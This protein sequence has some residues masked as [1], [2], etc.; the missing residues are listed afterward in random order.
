MFSGKLIKEGAGR[1]GSLKASYV[2][3][4]RKISPWYLSMIEAAS[5]TRRCKQRRPLPAR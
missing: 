4:R 2:A 5:A 1:T 3:K